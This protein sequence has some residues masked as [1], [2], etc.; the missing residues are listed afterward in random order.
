MV[1]RKRV[2]IDKD[3]CSSVVWFNGANWDESDFDFTPEQQDL[4]DSYNNLWESARRDL[5]NVNLVEAEA[6]EV[7]KFKLLQNLKTNRPDIEWV[8]WCDEFGGEVVY[9]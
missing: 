6:A 9:D 2:R 5:E 1:K 3:Y 8:Y 4:A 7:F